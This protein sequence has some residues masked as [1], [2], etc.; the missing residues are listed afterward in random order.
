M[1]VTV[2]AAVEAP[3]M[4]QEVGVLTYVGSVLVT[5]H[6]ALNEV[7]S[8]LETMVTT[9]AGIVAPGMLRMTGTGVPFRDRVAVGFDTVNTTGMSRSD[10]AYCAR[11][12]IEPL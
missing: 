1:P 10:W 2:A 3:A 6:V 11:Y 9:G 7:G 4:V 8:S 5:T 12:P